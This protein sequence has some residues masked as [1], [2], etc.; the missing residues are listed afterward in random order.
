MIDYNDYDIDDKELIQAFLDYYKLSFNENEYTILGH[1]IEIY[2]QDV[3]EPHASPGIYDV[4]R[5]EW[6]KD[7]DCVEIEF[8]EEH[9]EK[10]R[11]FL[12][13]INEYRAE[14]DNEEIADP[15]KFYEELQNFLEEI[16]EYRASGVGKSEEEGMYTFENM[17]FKWLRR[18][19][20]LRILTDLKHDVMQFI[21]DVER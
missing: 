12:D 3:T 20:T 2:F 8:T 21:Y 9:K 1:T 7:P 6:I 11:E 4:V 5:N 10:A 14:W 17:V 19:G 15:E 18:N 13:R 16:K